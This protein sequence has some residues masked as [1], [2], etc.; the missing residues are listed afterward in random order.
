M[1]TIKLILSCAILALLVQC[2]GISGGYGSI[3]I[4]SYINPNSYYR[5]YGYYPNYIYD[6]GFRYHTP[7][8]DYN[9][10]CHTETHH[11]R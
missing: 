4:D 9:S 11:Y 6:N 10:H 7:Y 8:N 5:P 3:G 2:D 1:K